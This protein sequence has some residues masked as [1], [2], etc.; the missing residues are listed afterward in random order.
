MTMT[1]SSRLDQDLLA[2]PGGIT[3]SS[4]YGHES[5]PAAGW[6][7]PPAKSSR[8]ALR[9]VDGLDR[10]EPI[11]APATAAL[12]LDPDVTDRL[13]RCAAT[14]GLSVSGLLRALLTVAAPSVSVGDL[15][16]VSGNADVFYKVTRI[17]NDG[18]AFLEAAHGLHRR[19]AIS[20]PGWTPAQRVNRVQEN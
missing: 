19:G 11:A 5:T 17:G 18:S 13:Q 20:S 7:V 3:A 6:P 10:P 14:A 1:L 15:V 16:H 2:A 8:P 9:L 4:A 12:T